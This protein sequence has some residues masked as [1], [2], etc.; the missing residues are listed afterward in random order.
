MR[1]LGEEHRVGKLG[2][3]YRVRKLRK[4]HRVR[5]LGEEPDEVALFQSRS[6]FQC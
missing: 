4:E 3:E 1:K 5:K 6:P 2:E